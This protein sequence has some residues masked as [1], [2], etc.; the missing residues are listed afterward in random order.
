[1]LRLENVHAYYGQSHVLQGISL[2]VQPGEIVGLLGR[3]GMGK[4]TTLKSV[5]GLVQ[6]RAGRIQLNELTI[7]RRP[8]HRIARLGIGYIPQGQR[9][10]SELTV[11]ENLQ[12]GLS[13]G[14]LN[15]ALLDK[16]TRPFPV[17]KERLTQAAGTLSGGEQ[18][19]LAIARAMLA[20][21]KYLLMDE[22]TEGLMPSMVQALEDQ[23]NV[24]KSEGLGILIAEQNA[25]TALR[26]CD[27]FYI[28]EKGSV[29]AESLTHETSLEQL[30]KYLGI[31]L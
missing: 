20:Q 14:R 6:I 24:M 3:N 12:L 11:L 29:R 21:P 23:I 26:V 1:M 7:S 5:M 2:Q 17:L 18:Q 8:A 22:P 13:R 10:F 25:D 15:G 30:Q 31:G 4:T 16:V 19:M 9:V 27:R 28:L